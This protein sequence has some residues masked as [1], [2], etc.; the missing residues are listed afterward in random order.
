[1]ISMLAQSEPSLWMPSPSSTVAGEVDGLF[2]FILWICVAMF[3]LILGLMIL[4]IAKYR[5][6]PGYTPVKSPSH[7]TA[8]ELTWTIIPTIVVMVIFYAGFKGYMNIATPP[9]NAYEIQVV[10]QKWKWS[11]IYPNGQE[12]FGSMHVPV[13]RPVRL[14]LRSQD[15]IHSLYIPAF[16]VKKDCVPGRLN[17]MWFEATELGEFD[18]Y[19]AEYCGQKHSKMLTTVVVQEPGVFVKWLDDAADY[20]KDKPPAEA[21]KLVY[22]KKGCADCH[23][24]DGRAKVGPSFQGLFGQSRP[25]VGGGSVTAEE[26]YVR[27]AVL[28][29][30]KH[31]V[32]GFDNVMP[33]YQGRLKEEEI[34]ALI[35]FMKSL[36]E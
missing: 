25:L 30:G 16:R 19:C 21:G 4:F 8:L 29:P 31:V 17:H 34:T 15:V 24:L 14:V 2:Y 18:L 3:V 22:Q 20:L 36:D 23:T 35:A 13:N 1:M 5:Q 27:D 33:S 12:E 6:R 9:P 28:E 11:F 10:S 7:S 26:N 32:A